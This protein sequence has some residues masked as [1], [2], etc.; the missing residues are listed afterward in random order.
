M[1]AGLP[2]PGAAP[3]G[4]LLCSALE[5]AMTSQECCGGSSNTQHV[6]LHSAAIVNIEN[7]GFGDRHR[8]RGTKR[9]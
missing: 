8:I 2:V 5:E 7:E 6:Q 1:K 3:S 9:I 4:L